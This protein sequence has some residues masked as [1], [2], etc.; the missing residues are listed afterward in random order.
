MP[1]KFPY[2]ELYRVMMLQIRRSVIRGGIVVNAKPIL[3]LSIID[4]VQAGE[5]INNQFYYTEDFAKAYKETWEKYQP[6]VSITPLCKPFYYLT[7]DEFWHIQWKSKDSFSVPTDKKMREGVAYGFLD[8]ALWDLLQDE[9]NR[10][11]YR[12]VIIDFF[13]NQK[14]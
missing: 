11:Y 4:Q 13:L 14:Y 6:G 5:V 3:L 9:T 1:S 12:K 2:I 10:D 8:N 7:N